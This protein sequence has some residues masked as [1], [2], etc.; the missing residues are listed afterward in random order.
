[1]PKPGKSPNR[2]NPMSGG[3][4][5]AAAVGRGSNQTRETCQCSD[6]PDRM[7]PGHMAPGPSGRAIVDENAVMAGQSADLT[8]RTSATY[9]ERKKT[10]GI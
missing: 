3:I 4:G 9:K 1:M 8:S 10:F 2:S 7:R 6:N 5:A